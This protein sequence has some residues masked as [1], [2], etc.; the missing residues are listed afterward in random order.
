M[1]WLAPTQTLTL[2]H[3]DNLLTV[4]LRELT[5]YEPKYEE[6]HERSR[7]ILGL[8]ALLALP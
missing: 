2:A 1:F 6:V 8:N 3:K 5:N 4:L 7:T